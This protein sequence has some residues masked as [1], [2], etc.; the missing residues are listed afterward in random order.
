MDRAQF[1]NMT[2]KQKLK[3]FFGYYGMT[4]AAVLGVC[5]V[6]VMLV[7]AVFWPQKVEDVCVLLYSDT[8]TQE[9][10]ALYKREIESRNTGKSA[11]V[12]VCNIS[13][14]YGSQAFAAKVGCDL[15]DLVIAPEKEMKL[16]VDNGFLLNYAP[17][18]GSTMYMGIP[19]TAREGNLLEDVI[20]YLNEK[21]PM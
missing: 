20:D 16:M 19:K 4:I 5:V 6:A 2:V 18:E 11:S 10:C 14:P 8:V 15:I 12:Q 1:K 13:D 3:W 7:K 9:D 21:I 17:V